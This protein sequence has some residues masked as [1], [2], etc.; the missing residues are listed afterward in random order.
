MAETTSTRKLYYRRTTYTE[1]LPR[2]LQQMLDEALFGDFE[3]VQDRLEAVNPEAREFRVIGARKRSGAF[4]CGRLIT[5]TR[6]R[7]Q[8]VFAENPDA[9][10]LPLSAIEPPKDDK[11]QPQQF[12]EGLLYFCVFEN[13]VVVLQSAALKSAGLEQHIAWLLRDKAAILAANQGL[14]L[15]DEPQEATRERIRRSHVKR[16]SIG[17]PLL[18]GE[19]K[20]PAEGARK[21]E[22][23]FRAEGSIMSWL[24]ERMDGEDF[25]RLGLQEAVFEGNLEVWIEI[26]YPKRS[27]SH[28]DDSVKLLDELALAFRDFDEDQARLELADGTTVMGK[29]MKISTPVTVKLKNGLVDEDELYPEMCAWLEALI[30]NEQIAL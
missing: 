26:R 4:L 30:K 1:T 12:T 29:E 2:T 7:H 18:E 9:T 13:H 8:S 22:T 5:F 3:K 15:S 27:R 21:E 17:R 25:A 20:L 10:D 23:R 14:A 11:G 19:V 28:P 24:K 16:V 6:G